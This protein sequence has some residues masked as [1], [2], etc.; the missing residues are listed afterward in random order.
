MRVQTE[1]LK[2]PT[3]NSAGEGR[4]LDSFIPVEANLTTRA[5]KPAKVEWMM[6]TQGESVT[7]TFQYIAVNLNGAEKVSKF[8]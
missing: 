5:Q 1:L 2:R 6:A 7:S 8:V 3:R 4:S